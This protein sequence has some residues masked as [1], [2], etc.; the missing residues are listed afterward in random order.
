MPKGV[1]KS[2]AHIISQIYPNWSIRSPKQEVLMAFTTLY[3]FSGVLFFITGTL[4]GGKRI[5][6]SKPFDTDL[7]IELF[8]RYEVTTTVIVPSAL[9]TLLQRDAERIE[10]VEIVLL[11]G[12][13]IPKGLRSSAKRL[14]PKADVLAV[15]GMTEVNF[16]TLPS[17]EQPEGCVGKVLANTHIKII[18][19]AGNNLG[20]CQQGEIVLKTR[21]I[22]SGYFD[23]PEKTAEAIDGDWVLSGDMGYIDDGGFL[24][25]INRKKDILKFNNYQVI[26]LIVANT[27]IP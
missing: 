8:N 21:V 20:P 6:T 14:F 9:I 27:H 25:V 16:V 12:S 19:D 1:C 10:S 13:T 15:Y 23:D 4:Y 17:V 7:F 22:F 26:A 5:I 11:G 3:W 24:Y 18:D 2:H